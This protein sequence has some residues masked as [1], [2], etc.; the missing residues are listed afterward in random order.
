MLMSKWLTTKAV[1]KYS[2][3]SSGIERFATGIVRRGSI[4]RR[5][6]M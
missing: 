1:N 5:G 2:G 6:R 3:L 4:T